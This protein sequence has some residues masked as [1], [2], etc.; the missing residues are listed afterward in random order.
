[1][2]RGSAGAGIAWSARYLIGSFEN[3]SP[4]P[5]APKNNVPRRVHTWPASPPRIASDASGAAADHQASAEMNTCAV[6]TPFPSLRCPPA[7]PSHS[8]AALPERLQLG[9]MARPVPPR[10]RQAPARLE[11]LKACCT[12][13][14]S[15]PSATADS[16]GA[17][18]FGARHRVGADHLPRAALAH[19]AAPGPD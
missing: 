12:C 10:C 5:E 19:E 11:E 8:P 2:R 17:S 1:M 7:A 3:V 15:A 14:R 6:R 18:S 13:R 4:K 9:P 16:S